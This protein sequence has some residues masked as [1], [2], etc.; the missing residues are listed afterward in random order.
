MNMSIDTMYV[1]AHTHMKEK[2][3]Y[4]EWYHKRDGIVYID[5][6]AF[7]NLINR[8]SYC[9]DHLTNPINGIFWYLSE[10]Y[11]QIQMAQHLAAMSRIYKSVLTWNQFLSVALWNIP[12]RPTTEWTMVE[13]FLRNGCLLLYRTAKQFGEREISCD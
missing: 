9:V 7:E 8:K 5:D 6:V 10:Y 1:R 12:E 4:P 2:G 11:S 3:R 13:D